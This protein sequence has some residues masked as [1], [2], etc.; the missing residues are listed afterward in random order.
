[1]KN[2]RKFSYINECINYKCYISIELI[3]LKELILTRHKK[4]CDICR[5][6][7]FIDKGF[8]FQPYVCNECVDVLMMSVNLSDIAILNINGAAYCCIINGI[9]KSEAINLLLES[10]LSERKVGHCKT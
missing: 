2:I 1:M 3:F 8:N 10:N 5:Y 7:Y 4:K 6:W 9:S